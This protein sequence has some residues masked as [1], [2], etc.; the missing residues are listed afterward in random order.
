MA[1][2]SEHCPKGMQLL[3]L[4]GLLASCAGTSASIVPQS[5]S[6][7]RNA[8]DSCLQSLPRKRGSGGEQDR[9]SCP[10]CGRV[11]EA[12]KEPPAGLHAWPETTTKHD[13]EPQPETEAEGTSSSGSA[14]HSESQE[15]V[16]R[17]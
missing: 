12:C 13:D 14:D 9:G 6:W 1:T 15:E 5:C 17:E 11:D 4:L 8:C 10:P 3:L 16:Q 7:Y 2:Q